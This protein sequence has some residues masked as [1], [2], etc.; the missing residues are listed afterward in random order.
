MILRVAEVTNLRVVSI[1]HD[2]LGCL[3]SIVR[4]LLAMRHVV[5]ATASTSC[6]SCCTVVVYDIACVVMPCASCIVDSGVVIWIT[7]T[8]S[9]MCVS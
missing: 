7:T 3:D 4:V 1:P 8:S 9:L 5:P 6:I 2:L